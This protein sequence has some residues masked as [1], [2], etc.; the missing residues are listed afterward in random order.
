MSAQEFAKALPRILVYEGGKVD[1]PR[2]P[3]GRTNKGITQATYSSYRRSNNLTSQDVYLIS[4]V[5]VASIYKS[6]YWDKVLGDQLPEGL[7]LCVFDGAVNSGVSRSGIW[8]QQSLGSAY[9]GQ[10]DGLF[11][12]KTL[13]AIADHD[14]IDAIITSYCQHR[15]GTL[16]ALK[17]WGT[18][19]KGWSARIANVQKTSLSWAA[20]APAPMPVDVTAITG[21]R[22]AVVQDNLEK[23]FV[24]Q[25]T[26]HVITA[27]GSVGTLASE[28]AAQ[29]SPLSD[30][31]GWMK[32]V[33]GGLTLA[34]VCA[35]IAVKIATDA[36]A[37]ADKGAAKAEVDL[38]ADA[39]SP[40]VQVNDNAAVAVPPMVVPELTPAV[41]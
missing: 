5:E 35:G 13:Q 15:L 29:V 34:A 27:A 4:N 10:I 19:G 17:L 8:L 25:M 21:H 18:Y 37:L 30:T 24:S 22:K 40:T 16:K 9:T 1:D 36:S 12:A 26:T 33:F 32:Y 41:A 31:F 2:D 38:D 3:G 7:G 14:D 39:N 23:P 28:T 6:R 20:A 11:G